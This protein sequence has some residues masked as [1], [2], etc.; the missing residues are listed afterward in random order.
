MNTVLLLSSLRW[1]AELLLQQRTHGW[2]DGWMDGT[3]NDVATG[4]GADLPRT[5]RP[6]RS[7]VARFLPIE[8]IC[9]N[10]LTANFSIETASSV[11]PTQCIR[12]S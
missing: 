11:A 2:M 5:S 10:L 9:W 8:V 3:D 6:R 12:S 1:R 4:G 7:A